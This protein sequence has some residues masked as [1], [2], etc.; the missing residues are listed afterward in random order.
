MLPQH[1]AW[2]SVS[3]LGQPNNNDALSIGNDITIQTI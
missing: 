2:H 1:V 3:Q